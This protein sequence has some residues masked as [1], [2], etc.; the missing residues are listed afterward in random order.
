MWGAGQAVLRRK[1][2]VI[3]AYPSKEK[4]QK[5]NLTSKGYR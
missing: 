1:F 5:S 2:I 3:Q 4:S